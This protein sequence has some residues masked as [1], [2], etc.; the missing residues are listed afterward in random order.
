MTV[1]FADIYQ[2][3]IRINDTIIYIY[4]LFIQILYYAQLRTIPR[5]IRYTIGNFW[6]S[7]PYHQSGPFDLFHLCGQ[8]PPESIYSTLK[9]MYLQSWINQCHNA[10]LEQIVSAYVYLTSQEYIHFRLFQTTFHFN[11]LVGWNNN[12]KIY[13]EYFKSATKQEIAYIITRYPHQKHRILKENLVNSELICSKRPRHLLNPHT[14]PRATTVARGFVCV[15]SVVKIA[16]TLGPISPS[17]PCG[18][19]SPFWPLSPFG[20][21]SPFMPSYPGSPCT[22]SWTCC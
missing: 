14:K 3:L 5:K 13:K 19:Y 17:N 2:L 6:E 21:Y 4:I 8:S 7:L 11:I 10:S 16:I 12:R 1:S 18:P 15:D 22:K 20:P 9:L